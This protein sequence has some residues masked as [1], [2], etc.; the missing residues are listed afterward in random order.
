[1][2]KL[3]A[4]NNFP[5]LAPVARFGSGSG[6]GIQSPEKEISLGTTRRSRQW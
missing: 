3:F 6:W 5:Y 1:M 4:A 2:V